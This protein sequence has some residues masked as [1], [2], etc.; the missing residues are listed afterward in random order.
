[1]KSNTINLVNTVSI[2]WWPECTILEGHTKLVDYPLPKNKYKSPIWN[3]LCNCKKIIEPSN[4]TI[5]SN[6]CRFRF[7]DQQQ[8]KK[9]LIKDHSIIIHIQI[10]FKCFIS[11]W[12]VFQHFCGGDN[13]FFL[14]VWVWL[15]SGL[16]YIVDISHK[17]DAWTSSHIWSTGFRE[18]DWNVNNR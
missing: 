13:Q 9:T 11:F 12:E 17:E 4:Y 16:V 2:S 15:W 3:R 8:R 6:W 7:S 1:M 5:S 10:R 18:E 14:K